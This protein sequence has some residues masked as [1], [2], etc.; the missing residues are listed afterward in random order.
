MLREL[1]NI[2]DDNN[3]NSS[4]ADASSSLGFSLR[5]CLLAILA[6]LSLGTLAYSFILEEHWSIIDSLYFSVVTFTSVG[7]GDLTPTTMASKIFTCFFGFSGLAFLGAAISTIGSSLLGKQQDLLKKAETASRHQIKNAFEGMPK[8]VQKLRQQSKDGVVTEPSSAAVQDIGEQATDASASAASSEPVGWKVTVQKAVLKLVPSISFLLIGGLIMAK[9]EGWNWTDSIYY[10][11]ITGSTIGFG[12]VFPQSP[13]GRLWGIF[14]IPLAVAAAGDVLGSIGSSLIE[15][16]QA[17]VFKELMSRDIS[18]ENL[19][20]MDED[21]SGQVSREEYV[22]FM[23]QEMGLVEPEEFDEL[24][25]QFERLDADGS[26]SLDKTDL[27]LMA[28][29][30]AASKSSSVSTQQAI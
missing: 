3:K 23:L 9:L 4:S 26:G 22:R 24:Y 14:F 16:R 29:H 28:Q 11:I 12:D 13:R 10:S 19:L 27:H 25:G 17:A 1:A 7:Y 30:R 8:V 18:V 15:R 2:D 20:T 5:E 6:Y 21:G